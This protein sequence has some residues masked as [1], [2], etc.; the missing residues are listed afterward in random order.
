MNKEATYH[1]HDFISLYHALKEN[2]Y[3][4]KHYITITQTHME[5]CVKY[6][7]NM[8]NKFEFERYYQPLI[9][10]LFAF[11]KKQRMYL[12]INIW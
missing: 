4:D 8:R 11:R 1:M 3:A 5:L 9:Q 6:K 7:Q 12:N 2:T 10:L